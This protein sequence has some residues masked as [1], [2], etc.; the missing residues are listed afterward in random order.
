[1]KVFGVGVFSIGLQGSLEGPT[2]WHAQ[3][4][5]RS[6][7]CSLGHRSISTST[8]GEAARTTLPPIEV[9]AD[10]AR[11]L[12]KAE[13][14][15]AL[16]P[17]RNNLRVSLRKMPAA[18]ERAHPA[19][20]RPAASQLAARAAARSSSTRSGTDRKTDD[21]NRFALGRQPGGGL[22]RKNDA[23][24]PFAP[25]QYQDFA[26]ADRLSKPAFQPMHGG[27]DLSVD[28]QQLA[29]GGLVKRVIRYEEIIIDS[30]FQTFPA[31]FPRFLRLA[32]HFFE[33]ARP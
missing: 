2:P 18:A 16:R 4:T 23:F 25:A 14:W 21:V 15:R 27:L 11:E 1:M 12:D 13:N 33:G 9:L 3:G 5:A 29:S 22:Q 8:W 10:P 7:C 30:N 32:L 6:R 19:P 26:D 24:E 17:P 28:G 20:G 31:P